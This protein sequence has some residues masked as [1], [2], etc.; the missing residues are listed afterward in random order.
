MSTSIYCM[1][2]ILNSLITGTKGTYDNI[3]IEGKEPGH[4]GIEIEIS[5]FRSDTK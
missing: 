4:G 2:K 1:D 5:G 3:L